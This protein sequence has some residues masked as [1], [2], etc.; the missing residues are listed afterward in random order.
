MPSKDS[1]QITKALEILQTWITVIPQ[2]YSS[3]SHLSAA[4]NGIVSIIRILTACGQAIEP[5]LFIEKLLYAI[6]HLP[7][8]HDLL[9]RYNSIEGLTNLVTT[10]ER[11]T[12]R[13]AEEFA[14]TIALDIN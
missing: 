12:T 5:A 8:R 13:F 7:L 6:S 4:D 2:E 1:A 9:E 11:S 14:L 3:Y 10:Y